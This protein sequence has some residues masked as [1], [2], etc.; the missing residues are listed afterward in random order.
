MQQAEFASITGAGRY[1]SGKSEEFAS[2]KAG[3]NRRQLLASLALLPAI[4][5]LPVLAQVPDPA[6]AAWQKWREAKMAYG[7][8]DGEDGYDDICRAEDVLLLATPISVAGA[9]AQ[10]RC[11]LT[12]V[13]DEIGWAKAVALGLPPHPRDDRG[14]EMDQIEAQTLANV[15]EFLEARI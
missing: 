6:V 4:A 9:I 5:A 2:P 12:F 3:E 10:L 1:I 11:V 15:I 7:A 14:R 8:H 13:T